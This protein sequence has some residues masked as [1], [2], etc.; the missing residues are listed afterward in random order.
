MATTNNNALLT[1]Q[2]YNSIIHRSIPEIN[3]ESIYRETNPNII[4]KCPCYQDIYGKCFSANTVYTKCARISDLQISFKKTITVHITETLNNTKSTINYVQVYAV[5]RTTGLATLM[6]VGGTDLDKQDGHMQ[7]TIDLKIDP[8]TNYD[9][10]Y[11]RISVGETTIK[12]K[13]SITENYTLKNTWSLVG[14]GTAFNYNYSNTIMTNIY[15]ENVRYLTYA[16]FWLNVGVIHIAVQNS[17]DG[18]VSTTYTDTDSKGTFKE[19][20][21]A[22]SY[23]PSVMLPYDATGSSIIASTA[24]E[25]SEASVIA[26]EPVLTR[27]I[28]NPDNPESLILDISPT[29][30][31]QSVV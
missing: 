5:N 20:Q 16:D 4:K 26:E 2:E 23:K 12:R 3:P 30:C 22:T 1:F 27:S 21:P 10:Y 29:M 9:D 17:G 11:P 14:E 6:S 15:G 24:S 28:N 7:F 18:N 25:V 31:V 8:R 13:F 19:W